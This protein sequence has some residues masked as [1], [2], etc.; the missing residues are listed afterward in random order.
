M[1]QVNALH[2][3]FRVN[4]NA[5]TLRQLKENWELIGSNETGRI[6]D[7]RKR[8]IIQGKDIVCEE[9]RDMPSMNTYRIVQAMETSGQRLFT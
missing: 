4:G 3:L 1:S 2:D 5:L 7:L 6:S 8:L 9:H